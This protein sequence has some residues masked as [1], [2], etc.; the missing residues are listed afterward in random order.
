MNSDETKIEHDLNTIKHKIIARE[1]SNQVKEFDKSLFDSLVDYVL[2]GSVD[3]N[4]EPN[5]FILRFIIKSGFRNKSREDIE[6]RVI[7]AN[8]LNNTTDNI[9]IPILDFISSQ[10]FNAFENI[11]YKRVKK[12]IDKVRVRVEM[13]R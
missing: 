6:D 8:G 9:Y 1:T 5:G 12:I 11:G 10:K 2:I 13:E 7:T 3:E 4:D